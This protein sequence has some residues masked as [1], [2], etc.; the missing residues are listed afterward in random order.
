MKAKKVTTISDGVAKS[1]LR[2]STTA[3]AVRCTT[4]KIHRIYKSGHANDLWTAKNG[5]ENMSYVE[6]RLCKPSQACSKVE[7]GGTVK[8]M[9]IATKFKALEQPQE[10]QRECL[11]TRSH[12]KKTKTHLSDQARAPKLLVGHSGDAK[13]CSMRDEIGNPAVLSNPRVLRLVAS[14]R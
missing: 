11:P 4:A 13:R 12:L 14:M 10:S 2:G 8:V 6:Y 5:K 3:L 9:T 1:I 7:H